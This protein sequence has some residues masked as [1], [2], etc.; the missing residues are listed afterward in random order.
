MND[1]ITIKQVV[2]IL[3][4]DGILTKVSCPD[5][6]LD[7][8]FDYLSYSSSDVKENTFF[9]CKGAAFKEEYLLDAVKKGAGAY[10]AEKCFTKT[11]PYILTSDIRKAMSLVAIAFYREADR[12][13]VV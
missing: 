12:K 5:E 1:S 3:K 8:P 10:L 6:M 13:S 9:I 4:Q 2:E 11:V 7:H